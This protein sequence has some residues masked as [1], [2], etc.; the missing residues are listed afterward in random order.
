LTGAGGKPLGKLDFYQMHT[1]SH[2][3][4][5]NA[6]APFKVCIMLLQLSIINRNLIISFEQRTAAS[7]GLDKP[8]VIGEFASVCAENKS[9][10]TL[11][12]YFYNNGYQVILNSDRKD[13][14]KND[15]LNDF[16]TIL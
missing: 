5:W 3:G 7:Y 4:V 15:F 6:D 11:F 10:Q 13:D 8:L 1:Y 14:D 2:N 12:Q 16:I 9:I